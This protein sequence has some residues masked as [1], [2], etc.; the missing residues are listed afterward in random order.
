MRVLLTGG[1]GRDVLI[2]G[3]GA[4][5]IVGD[6]SDDILIAGRTLFDLDETALALI[7]AEWAS[8]RSYASRVANLKGTGTGTRANGLVVL[9]T[10]GPNTTV[11][12]D[13]VKDTLTGEG[14]QDATAGPSPQRSEGHD[15]SNP[16]TQ[17]P[18]ETPE[19]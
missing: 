2:G 11:F 12:D 3:A 7:Q 13:G 19:S 16:Q 9:I 15:T 4:D 8:T 10:D 6:A 18:T 17:R 1:A 5:K 14:E